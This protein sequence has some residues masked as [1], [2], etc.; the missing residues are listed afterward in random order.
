MDR[1]FRIWFSAAA[2]AVGLLAGCASESKEPA[3]LAL[4]KA[5]LIRYVDSGDYARDL[6][7][8][9]DAAITWIER[10]IRSRKADERLCVVLDLDETL[11][12]N[13]SE[14]RASDFGYVPEQWSK[15]V[16][17]SS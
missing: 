11:L 12:L 16:K 6:R 15:W 14:I 5:Q 13:W 17:S 9:A 7:Q 4:H 2:L 10:R 1:F 3:N 8:V